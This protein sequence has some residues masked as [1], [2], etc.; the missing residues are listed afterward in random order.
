VAEQNLELEA[1]K[2]ALSEQLQDE[3]EAM[4]KTL[5]E[6]N[7]ELEATKKATLEQ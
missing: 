2:K 7:L 4:K 5:A 1:A 3:L 6:Q